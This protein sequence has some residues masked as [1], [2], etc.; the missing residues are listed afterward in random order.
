MT[1]EFANTLS[2]INQ[3]K[4]ITLKLNK[5]PRD[6]LIFVAREHFDSPQHYFFPISGK[7]LKS[8]F[9]WECPRS[10]EMMQCSSERHNLFHAHGA[11]Q[12]QDKPGSHTCQ[13]KVPMTKSSSFCPRIWALRGWRCFSDLWKVTSIWFQTCWDVTPSLFRGRDSGVTGALWDFSS[14][15]LPCCL[16]DF[17]THLLP[18][19]QPLGLCRPCCFH[20]NQFCNVLCLELNFPG[21][22][23]SS[24]LHEF[25]LEGEFILRTPGVCP[26]LVKSMVWFCST[27]WESLLWTV[28]LH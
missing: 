11:A 19:E 13:Y 24:T 6:S 27:R 28:L 18:E 22:D 16:W 10:A 5:N 23:A 25:Q 20:S 26:G 8:L 2:I 4:N 15:P 17:P 21:S 3:K 7:V 14:H 12:V 1:F 9:P